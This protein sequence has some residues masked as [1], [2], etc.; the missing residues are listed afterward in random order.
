MLYTKLVLMALFWS[1]VFPAVNI[2]LKSMGLFTSVF[3]RFSC[4]ALIL[5]ALLRLRSRGLP[6][7]SPRETVLVVGLGL[8]GI[9]VYNTL[10]TAGLAL[11]EASRAALIVPTNPAFTALF[12]ALFLKERLGATRAA[13]IALCVLGALWVLTRG[14]IF[15]LGRLELGLGE[16]LLVLCIFMWSAY[17]LLGRVALSGLPALALTA[18]VMTAGALML[19]VPAWLEHDSLARVT[20]QG[21]AALAYLIVFGTALPF[22][23][24]YEGVKAL[25]A[26]RRPVHQPRAAARGDR[27]GADPRR[28]ADAGAVRRRRA[29]RSGSISDKQAALKLLRPGPQVGLEGPRRARLHVQLPEELGD[30]VGGEHAVGRKLFHAL[31]HAFARPAVVD[32]AV[33]HDVGDVDVLRPEL[34]RHRLRHLAQAALGRRKRG[35]LRRAAHRCRGA[36]EKNRAFAARNHAPRRLAPEEKPR[37][38]AQAPDLL[39]HLGRRVEDRGAEI[40]P[41]VEDRHLDRAALLH[42]L[43]EPRYLAFFAQIGALPLRSGRENHFIGF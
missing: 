2:V 27:S 24:F 37:V 20:W 36:R 23:W 34:A 7:P 21:W 8:L 12:A 31:G 11:V 16:L 42:A 35:E 17:T 19:A 5:L 38:A 33:D 25:G 1:G 30:R 14:N 40:R 15:L 9:A 6:R 10:F 39:E 22:L 43:E 3:L 4:A 32:H 26:A 41:G 18:Y 13:G 29:R 28:G